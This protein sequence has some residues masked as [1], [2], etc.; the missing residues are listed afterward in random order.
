[1]KQGYNVHPVDHVYSRQQVHDSWNVDL[2]VNEEHWSKVNIIVHPVVDS[3]W[4]LD[5]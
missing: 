1:M 2:H 5:L 3:K 4:Q